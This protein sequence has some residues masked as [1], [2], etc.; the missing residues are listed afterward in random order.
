MPFLE[1][2]G[3]KFH[4]EEKGSGIPF[5]FQHG[6]GGDIAQP[7]GLFRPPAGIR[8]LAFECRGHGRSSLG[9]KEELRLSTF[10]DDLFTLLNYLEIA[11][12]IVGGISVGAAVAL[13]FAT[14]YPAKV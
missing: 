3:L 9:P 6:L 2:S 12:A 5:V 14:R 13:E 7:F 11:S 1:Q 10:A 8:L 4:Y